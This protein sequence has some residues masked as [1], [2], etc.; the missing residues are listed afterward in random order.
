MI[1]LAIGLT[2]LAAAVATLLR[3]VAKPRKVCHYRGFPQHGR[4]LRPLNLPNA[5]VVYVGRA[6][7]ACRTRHIRQL[8][9]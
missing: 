3:A 1:F 2:L 8:R 5:G 4:Q 6:T 7:D 9:R